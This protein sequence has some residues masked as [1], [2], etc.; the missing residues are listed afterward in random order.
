MKAIGKWSTKIHFLGL[1]PKAV[2]PPPTV[3]RELSAFFLESQDQEMIRYD[4]SLS[5]PLHKKMMTPGPPPPFL[6]LSP[7]NIFTVSLY[8]VVVEYSSPPMKIIKRF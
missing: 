8:G 4:T 1:S 6:G 5:L 7:K 2:G 3:F